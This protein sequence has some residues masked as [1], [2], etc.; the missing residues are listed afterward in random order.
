MQVEIRINNTNRA[1]SITNRR[2]AVVDARVIMAISGHKTRAMFRRYNRIDLSDG[3]G[4]M[5]K[6]EN[7]LSE[8]Q[9]REGEGKEN[10]LDYCNITAVMD[11]E[12]S[13]FHNLLKILASIQIFES[14]TLR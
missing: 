4:A 11:N 7:Y 3:I 12:D 6:L 10:E 14:R 5:G 13:S 2:M 8:N 9:G 1:I